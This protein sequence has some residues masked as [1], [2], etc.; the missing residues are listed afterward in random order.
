M[1]TSEAAPAACRWQY[2]R[3]RRSVLSLTVAATCWGV[4][5]Q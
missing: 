5:C 4:R 3:G 1:R 2:R